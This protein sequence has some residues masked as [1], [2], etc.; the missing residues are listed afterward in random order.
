LHCKAKVHAVLAKCG[1]AVLMGDMFGVDGTVLL[2]RLRQDGRLPAPFAAL[3]R[4]IDLV[5]FEIDVFAG[6]IRARR[7]RQAPELIVSVAVC[8]VLSAEL[9]T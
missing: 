4:L 8:G 5:D 9:P 2:D 6:L 7:G 3:G 1:I